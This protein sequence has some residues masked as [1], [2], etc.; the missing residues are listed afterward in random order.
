MLD[1]LRFSGSLEQDLMNKLKIKCT[2]YPTC[3][4]YVNSI[5]VYDETGGK[6]VR[7]YV[8]SNILLEE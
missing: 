5:D 2:R 1:N 8:Y 7:Q 3:I 4:Y 6:V